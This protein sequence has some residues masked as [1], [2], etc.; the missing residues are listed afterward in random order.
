MKESIFLS[1][2]VNDIKAKFSN[3]VSAIAPKTKQIVF[4]LRIESSDFFQR[5]Y[6]KKNNLKT[7]NKN[8]N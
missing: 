6:Q 3:G 5:L 7:I 4:Q 2:Q 1:T 8:E